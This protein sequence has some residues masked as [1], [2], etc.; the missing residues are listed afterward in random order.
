MI[1]TDDGGV[2]HGHRGVAAGWRILAVAGGSLYLGAEGGLFTP[3][4][5]S[6]SSFVEESIAIDHVT[7]AVKAQRLV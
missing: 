7:Q 2:R 6:M 5:P 3:K 1:F 4:S